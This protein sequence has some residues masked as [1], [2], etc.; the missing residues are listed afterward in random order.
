[1]SKLPDHVSTLNLNQQEIYRLHLKLAMRHKV[2]EQKFVKENERRLFVCGMAF[3]A[4]LA[5]LPFHIVR[6]W[7]DSLVPLRKAL[8]DL[9]AGWKDIGPARRRRF[10]TMRWGPNDIRD[11]SNLLLLRRKGLVVEV[12]GTRRISLF[13]LVKERPIIYYSIIIQ[14]KWVYDDTSKE[15]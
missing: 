2:Y 15:F 10:A 3:D 6:T 14:M 12:T 9:Q 1:M 8:L 7:S 5:F 11:I 4:E 13:N